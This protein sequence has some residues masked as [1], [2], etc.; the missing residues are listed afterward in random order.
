MVKYKY[1]VLSVIK[2]CTDKRDLDK[3]SKLLI[4]SQKLYCKLFLDKPEDF[5]VLETS[6]NHLLINRGEINV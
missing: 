1:K 4:K 3:V 6:I 2:L 5:F